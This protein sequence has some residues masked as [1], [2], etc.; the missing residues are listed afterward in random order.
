MRK[1]DNNKIYL[2]YSKI[3]GTSTQDILS[4]KLTLKQKLVCDRCQLESKEGL[5][6]KSCGK[7]LDEVETIEKVQDLNSFKSYIKPILLA[8]VSS[9][10]ILF[11]ISLG[12][13]SLTNS[14][15]TELTNSMN[16]LQIILGLNLCTINLNTSTI[17]S[18][19][20]SSVHLGVIPIAL[21]PLFVLLL[22][23]VI[24]IKNKNHKDVLYNSLGVGFIYGIILIIISMF[25]SRTSSMLYTVNSLISISYRYNITELFINGFILGFISTY[26]MGYRKK[27]FGQNIFLDVLKI[28]INSILI[29]Y[30]TIFIILLVTSMIDHNYIYNLGLYNYSKNPIIIISQLASYLLIFASMV[31]VTIGKNNLSILS[32]INGNLS[33]DVKLMLLAIIFLSLLVLILIGYSLRNKFKNTSFNIVLI[34][35][36]CYSIILTIISSFSVI[37]TNGSI[38]FLQLNNYLSN[39][40]MGAGI[41]TTFIISFIYSYIIL[42]IGYTLS[43]F[44]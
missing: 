31:P 30:I 18:S 29:L 43:D 21:I 8:S 20:S 35:S 17:M 11:L 4:D 34:F 19:G 22:S 5:Y 16:P 23:N 9:F 12:L 7:P 37:Y 39:I 28:A 44:E 25:S 38:P 2:N 41:I 32:I 10:L 13:K 40:Y 27:Y 36:I 6:C 33:F 14:S 26:L 1:L 24:F 15:I 3:D 42:K